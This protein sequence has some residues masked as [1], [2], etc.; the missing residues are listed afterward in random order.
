MNTFTITFK[1]EEGLLASLDFIL[2]MH[3][4]NQVKEWWDENCVNRSARS[5]TKH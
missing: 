5:I 4:V 1:T 3:S 2:D